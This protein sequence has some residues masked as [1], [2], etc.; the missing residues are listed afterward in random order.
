MGGKIP[1]PIRVQ[2]IE[3]WLE[4]K[5]R[6]KIAQKLQ[7]STGAV[8]S[9]IKDFRKDDSQFDLLREVAIKIKNLNMNIDSFA[10][11][12]RVYEV[13]REKGLLT[14]ITGKDSLELMQ[15]RIE[16]QIVALEVLCFKEKLSIQ[17]FVSL[18]TNMYNTA[19]KLG[20]PL[21][22]FP[23][24]I[25]ELKDR[26]DALRKKIGQIEA[27]KQ[28]VLRDYGL[29]L[30]SLQEYNAN[31]PLVVQIQNLKQQV[32]D[33][34]EDLQ[35]FK[36][37]LENEKFLDE[38]GEM[39]MWSI[40]ENE[41]DEANMELGFGRY[42]ITGGKPGLSPAYLRDMVM[43]VFNHPSKYVEVIREMMYIYNSQNKSTTASIN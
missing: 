5:S 37:D 27:K 13:L 38:Q 8:S 25:T 16:A 10:P 39:L 42:T 29:T 35:K 23:A 20:I 6:D 32:T 18:I 14:G 26:I 11:L 41:L 40:S 12:V 33:T 2:V 17:D 31:K 19:D 21:D 43:D 15:S 4:G 1:R 34:E 28:D 9:I 22:R 30:E 3:A 7:I 24:Y 36:Q